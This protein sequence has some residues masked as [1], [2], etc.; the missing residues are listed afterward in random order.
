MGDVSVKSIRDAF[1]ELDNEPSTKNMLRM[2]KV[3]FIEKDDTL[4]I[5]GDAALR[6]ANILKKEVKRPLSKGVIAAGER[7]AEKILKILLK[8]VV[9]E[10]DKAGEVVYYSVPAAPID[11][12]V[13]VIYHE[14]MFKKILT[15]FGYKAEA[16]NEA[17]AVA[18]AN[19]AAENFTALAM[20]CLTPG[21]H[22][23][24]NTGLVKIE[25]FKEGMKVLTL[26]SSWREATPTSREYHGKVYGIQAYGSGK[27]EL[28]ADHL[29]WVKKPGKQWGYL[30]ASEVSIGDLVQQPWD[31]YTL[32]TDR[33]YLCTTER[34][35][36]SEPI[37]TTVTLT[38]DLAE[39]LGILL[40][41][42]AVGGHDRNEIG[43]NIGN[44]HPDLINHVV[45]L[46]GKVFSK[47][48]SIY[49]HG[50]GATRIK[51]YSKGFGSW[52]RANCYTDS[53]EKSV[54]WAVCELSDAVLRRMLAGLVLT[55]GNYTDGGF[56][57]TSTSASLAQFAYLASQRLGMNPT[58]HCRGPR[59][60][61]C[62]EGG[63]R[64]IVGK[65]DTFSVSASGIDAKS[66][67]T[68][69]ED[70][71]RP[72]S[73]K[74]AYTWGS[75]VA[76]VTA[77]LER[78][79]TGPVYDVSVMEG[80]D[81]SFCLPGFAV[82]NCGAGMTN[83]A[84]LYQTMIGMKYGISIGGDWID[85][86]AAKATGRTQAQIMAI[87]EQGVDLLDP[88][89]GDPKYERER[90]AIAVYYKNLIKNVVETAKKEF[91]KSEGSVR[92]DGPIPIIISGGTAKA[93][94]F[95]E[96]FKQEFDKIKDFPL[97]ISEIRMAS[98]PLS[99]VAKGLLIAAS[100]EE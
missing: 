95:L 99:D 51:F 26:N 66:F 40:G 76:K 71:S 98:D 86:G 77:I 92:I 41:D 29:V 69:I 74:K 85:E 83:V 36:C 15:D 82:H 2:S 23:L 81:H 52:F 34:V 5:I 44:E 61:G 89:K 25:D 7:D 80:D 48:A 31:N 4:Y 24:T 45:S 46:I 57:F 47:K 78:E 42:G 39:L 21:Q 88:L 53:V 37:V 59:T 33:P 73:C 27:V 75:Q 28:T 20:S 8:E 55:D 67:V 12:D 62:V 96:F 70:L 17:A 49:P 65:K 30:P 97:E 10:P 22:I 64:T 60:G 35:T 68:W 54:P 32:E 91:R 3:P 6:M 87:K 56:S 84:L 16:M 63:T 100:L 72:R 14:A 13:D 94:N 50:E 93:G 38:D 11:R 9:G 43:I 19:A 79:Y 90:E 1:I 58:W 18:Y